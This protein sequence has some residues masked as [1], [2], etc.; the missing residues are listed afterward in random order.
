ML[1]GIEGIVYRLG[2]TVALLSQ[3]YTGYAAGIVHFR[4]LVVGLPHPLIA[5]EPWRLAK[6]ALDTNFSLEVK[7]NAATASAP[8]MRSLV[9]LAH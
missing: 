1:Q 2:H 3:R 6:P 5:S 9:A 4:S 7:R 8:D